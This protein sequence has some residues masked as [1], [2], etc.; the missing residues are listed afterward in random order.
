MVLDA[1]DPALLLWVQATLVLTSLRLYETVLGRLGPDRR[2]AYWQEARPVAALL[3]IPTQLQPGRLADLERY[4]RVMLRTAARP[5]AT[6]IRVARQVLHPFDRI[7][8]PAYWPGDAVA[9]ALVPAPL[10]AP[11][12]L[13][14]RLRERIF[15][16]LVIAIVRIMRTVLPSW[17]TVVPQARRFERRNGGA[18]RLAGSRLGRGTRST[19]RTPSR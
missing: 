8:G 16:A 6:S 5:D 11:F 7:P 10:R 19:S 17:L 3:G 9:A 15:L 4:E 12:G 13:R 18:T 14:Y 2:E 1:R